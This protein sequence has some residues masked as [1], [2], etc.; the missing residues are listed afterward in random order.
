VGTFT[1]GVNDL[2]MVS[3]LEMNANNVA[4]MMAAALADGRAELM[5]EV[6]TQA[7][8]TAFTGFP[9]LV[10][11][12]QEM[13]MSCVMADGA[14]VCGLKSAAALLKAPA[15]P[16][17]TDVLDGALDGIPTIQEV[18][19]DA[20]DP[21]AIVTTTKIGAKSPK[22]AFFKME[23]P[24]VLVDIVMND[25]VEGEMSLV[26]VETL[27]SQVGGNGFFEFES[28]AT[29]STVGNN[30]DALRSVFSSLLETSTLAP[31]FMR[32]SNTTDATQAGCFAQ[33]VLAGV[34]SIE[35]PVASLHQVTQKELARGGSRDSESRAI[36][37]EGIE[38]LGGIV[39]GLLQHYFEVKRVHARGIVDNAITS[40]AEI[41]I[42]T[43]FAFNATFPRFSWELH[44]GIS[45][46]LLS[47]FYTD[48]VWST[49]PVVDAT[50]GTHVSR[51]VLPVTTQL[52]PAAD[53]VV[54]TVLRGIADGG[55]WDFVVSATPGF[56]ILSDI[57][58][59]PLDLDQALGLLRKHSNVDVPE[60]MVS[61]F[62]KEYEQNP[63][64]ALFA[65]V[66]G[67]EVQDISLGP[68]DPTAVETQL[69][70]SCLLE[71]MTDCVPL[72]MGLNSSTEVD[73]DLL[74]T[75]FDL[76]PFDVTF[77]MIF[78]PM[79]LHF[80]DASVPSSS[81]SLGSF[82]MEGLHASS[83][84]NQVNVN[85]VVN[86]DNPLL[87]L[88]KVISGDLDA[89]KLTADTLNLDYTMDIQTLT[90]DLQNLIVGTG[91]DAAEKPILD[92]KVF[93]NFSGDRLRMAMSVVESKEIESFITKHLPP[94]TISLREDVRVMANWEDAESG[95]SP[96]LMT[97]VVNFKQPDFCCQENTKWLMTLILDIFDYQS[98]AL[99]EFQRTYFEGNLG[100]SF[101]IQLLGGLGDDDDSVNLSVLVPVFAAE[102]FIAGGAAAQ[103]ADVVDQFID[104]T[105][106][107]DLCL[108]GGLA[109]LDG[110][111]VA[112]GETAGADIIVPCI[113]KGVCPPLTPDNIQAIPGS[114]YS[115]HIVLGIDWNRIPFHL[116]VDTP[117]VAFGVTVNYRDKYLDLGTEEIHIDSR[118]GTGEGRTPL[119]IRSKLAVTDWYSFQVLINDFGNVGSYYIKIGAASENHPNTVASVAGVISFNVGSSLLDSIALPAIPTL[120]YEEDATQQTMELVSTTATTAKFRFNLFDFENPL[121]ATFTFRE[122]AMELVF[123]TVVVGQ[124]W[125]E[126]DGQNGII[127]N[128]GSNDLT[129]FFELLGDA[130]VASCRDDGCFSSTQSHYDC[131]PCAFSRML[132]SAINTEDTALSIHFRFTN[133]LDQ[134]VKFELPIVLFSESKETDSRDQSLLPPISVMSL[135]D[136]LMV[137]TLDAGETLTSTILA[138]LSGEGVAKGHMEIKMKNVFN[139]QINADRMATDVYFSSDAVDSFSPASGSIALISGKSL[140]WPADDR[141]LLVEGL[142]ENLGFVIPPGGTDAKTIVASVDWEGAGRAVNELVSK[143]RLCV[144]VEN[145]LVNMA[146]QCDAS[147]TTCEHS[148]R[149]EATLPLSLKDFSLFHPNACYKPRKDCNANTEPRFAVSSFGS[150][151][152][153]V[154]TASR[155][156]VLTVM[157]GK[158]AA[159]S[160]W[161]EAKQDMRNSWEVDFNFR[162][163]FGDCGWFDLGSCTRAGGFSFVIQEEGPNAYSN[164]NCVVEAAPEG[165]GDTSLI[166]IPVIF[167][168][169]IHCSG[170]KGVGNSVGVVYSFNENQMV[171]FLG[172]AIDQ[173]RNAMAVFHNGVVVNTNEKDSALKGL[174]QVPSDEG[175]ESEHSVRVK[176]D[177]LGEMLSIYLDDLNDPVFHAPMDLK[178][179]NDAW[180]GFTGRSDGDLQRVQISQLSMRESTSSAAHSRVQEE[181]QI[182]GQVLDTIRFHV[183]ARDLCEN[184]RH[185]GSETFLLSLTSPATNGQAV[186][187][188]DHEVSDLGDGRYEVIMVATDS[189]ELMVHAQVVDGDGN[190]SPPSRIGS[191]FVAP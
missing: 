47:R 177:G 116:V 38:M 95:L 103:N 145:L 155:G 129:A 17:N 41:V 132:A 77:D 24:R 12:S 52:P 1:K 115:F 167:H 80:D 66:K 126:V 188:P 45:N 13:P 25:V 81:Y 178:N 144:A 85:T 40:T 48:D 105:C 112:G 169:D 102:G 168:T 7:S 154:G 53:A 94:V 99:Y 91:F 124:M 55:A 36:M 30:P 10:D 110:L 93:E 97:T 122:F 96:S 98:D 158:S 70:L 35:V 89:V 139:M 162:S 78:P 19:I 86:I 23:M 107:S 74:L 136:E 190:V 175:R 123:D 5:I 187:I 185:I 131:V 15:S 21:N 142:N 4:D 104:P 64:N 125:M 159:G 140:P 27:P 176:Y 101:V 133:Y 62:G 34:G 111:H 182:L 171:S 117:A 69:D 92:M 83:T 50:A 109:S 149:F 163:V 135:L 100:D 130:D 157:N 138:V 67:L 72:R 76:L 183:D 166:G 189:G 153:T 114:S 2:D 184:Q 22:F 174:A 151:F 156:G 128:K 160:A 28:I 8:V 60:V 54:D 87:A 9:V 68:L 172:E 141:Y 71:D 127:L 82:E 79:A 58:S 43:P 11:F 6:T 46:D 56:S 121:P 106:T 59:E 73:L 61:V 29:V 33:Q 147:T 173:N 161:F 120:L 18:T 137:M 44:D 118:E 75:K 148:Q 191:F 181:G 164:E 186:P 90:N 179:F 37:G 63:I 108:F 88:A 134:E 42:K 152:R 150:G 84:T 14:F 49:L 146:F 31:I 32:S 16:S 26:S 20:V 165:V 65:F 113:F 180:M 3:V 39:P 143:Q 57:F 51:L 119:T 170:Y